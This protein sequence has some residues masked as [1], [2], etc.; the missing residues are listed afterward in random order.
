MDS[1]SGV[2]SHVSHCL[3]GEGHCQPLSAESS[4]LKPVLSLLWK[5]L[6][7]DDFC[8]CL[9]GFCVIRRQAF[10]GHLTLFGSRKPT[11]FWLSGKLKRKTVSKEK[12]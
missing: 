12:L 9:F 1:V 11:T 4:V 3:E 8:V 6:R 2:V 5:E 7:P 10:R